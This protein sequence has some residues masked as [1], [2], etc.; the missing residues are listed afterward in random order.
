MAYGK[1][2][3]FTLAVFVIFCTIPPL[4]AQ[5]R[6]PGDPVTYFGVNPEPGGGDPD[7]L[8][9]VFFEVPDTMTDTIYFAVNDPG[10]TGISPND[11]SPYT[12]EVTEF[13]LI[14][15]SGAY[16]A[17]RSRQYT[18][19]TPAD[20]VADG[21]QI[22][23]K[24]YTTEGGWDFFNG[25]SPA[26]G[27][28]IGNKYYFKIVIW[29]TDTTVSS[30]NA[31]QLDVSLTSGGTPTGVSAIRA[32]AYSWSVKIDTNSTEVWNLYPFVPDTATG[33]IEYRNWD[34]DNN[35]IQANWTAYNKGGNTLGPITVSGGNVAASTPYLIG[36]ETN[37]TWRLRIQ[38]DGVSGT[39]LMLCWFT[40]S[41]TGEVLPTYAAY[42]VPPAPHHVTSSSSAAVTV[43][44][45]STL[46]E[47]AIQ[48]VDIDGNPVP[49]SRKV[50][51]AVN[52]SARIRETNN[53][54]GLSVTNR[55]ITTTSDGLGW[56]RISDTV[57]ETVTV[58][59]TTDGTTAD[60]VPLISDR[61]PFT[62]P[63]GTND[64]ETIL[65]QNDAAPAI[66]YG[67]TTFTEGST[68]NIS[69][70]MITD[71]APTP[72]IKAANDI[73][74]RIPAT[75]NAV[76]NT[77]R[78]TP[79]FGG[80]ASLKVNSTVTYQDNRT[81]RIDVASDFASGDILTIANDGLGLQLTTPNSASVGKLELS[82]SGSGGPF[83]VVDGTTG[84][85]TINGYA[86]YVWTGATSTAWATA[87][88][89]TPNG[90]P[91]GA[92]INVLIPDT[93]AGSGLYPVLPGARTV[94]NL[95]IGSGARL[96][97]SGQTLTVGGSFSND[98]TLVLNGSEN[99]AGF[100]KDTNSGTVEY[101]GTG[102]PY[103]GL[104]YGNSYNNLSFT[105][106]TFTLNA[107][108]AIAGNLSIG[109]GATLVAGSNIITLSG[110]WT[111]N[112][113]GTFTPNTGT[114]SIIGGGP[115]YLPVRQI[116]TTFPV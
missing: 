14:G 62:G 15:G 45:G 77:A 107:N 28:H 110:S 53:T 85:V 3:V 111:K 26:Q 49:Y 66:A 40:N 46:K 2:I 9:V 95:T 59:I 109:A 113:V 63:L 19:G 51:V 56:V 24:S 57:A 32:F 31:F 101:S 47:V 70:I 12:D 52:G 114:V 65:F 13:Y 86:L 54:T 88:N 84:L 39:N 80:S 112:A 116:S 78:T 16:S 73:Y 96:T 43:S 94:Y 81:L 83:N 23:M 76:F 91:N 29:R 21:T 38:G 8:M 93:T 87:T 60:G 90:D 10:F 72:N 115:A 55:T 17:S 4:S 33:F 69:A 44:D 104:V 79:T 18:F 7:P 35:P 41:A 22:Q 42:Y 34:A 68:Q 27:E 74:I 64:S 50:H 82:Y 99:T 48:I 89:W 98:G 106:N 75:I 1:H 97:L 37:G 67:N 36:T 102:G 6:I 71:V 30:T 103:T 100:T 20:A 108:C 58:T 25:V 61:L 5:S 92:N 105:G 11:N